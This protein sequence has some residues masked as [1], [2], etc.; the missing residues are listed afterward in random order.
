MFDNEQTEK[1]PLRVFLNHSGVKLEEN[2]ITKKLIANL[3]LQTIPLLEGKKE[4]EIEDLYPDEVLNTKINGKTFS[5]END[6]SEE[7]YGKHVL[8]KHIIKEYN[9]INFSNFVDILNAINEQ[10]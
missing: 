10:C 9:N 7:H 2:V 4:C 1:K 6:D 3:Y 8:S 5:R